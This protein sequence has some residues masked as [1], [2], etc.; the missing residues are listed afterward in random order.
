M[1]GT[2]ACGTP[3]FEAARDPRRAS[4]G[5][6]EHVG[7]YT[8]L[9]RQDNHGLLAHRRPTRLTLVAIRQR[10]VPHGAVSATAWPTCRKTRQIVVWLT[11]SMVATSAWVC[12]WQSRTTSS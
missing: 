5:H 4:S 12:R 11:P 2:Y 8:V 7:L 1:L 3:F 9:Y 10:A 6:R